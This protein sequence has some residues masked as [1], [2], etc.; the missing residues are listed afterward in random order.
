MLLYNIGRGCDEDS[1]YSGIPKR[2]VKG[3][4]RRRK[5]IEDHF[6]AAMP[7]GLMLI[8]YCRVPPVTEGAYG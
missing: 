8:K 6:G 4:R 1:R 7:K 2:A 3:V 5:N